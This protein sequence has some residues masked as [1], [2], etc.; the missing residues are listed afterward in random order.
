M[1]FSHI[2]TSLARIWD[3]GWFDTSRFS[4][5]EINGDSPVAILSE[6]TASSHFAR[7]FCESHDPW[8]KAIDRHGPFL[9]DHF[10]CEWYT[11]IPVAKL[12][13]TLHETIQSYDFE[14]KLNDEQ[15]AT[16][17]N[18]ANSLGICN[19]WR[20][21]APDDESIRVDFAHIWWA[22]DEFVVYNADSSELSVAVI[23]FD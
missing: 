8:G 21:H 19:A 11:E 7:S 6:F 20:L 10:K 12:Q 4:V 13:S 9:L 3:H 1:N 16:I 15:T 18:W 5:L 23:G 2:D 22:F 17:D 14:P